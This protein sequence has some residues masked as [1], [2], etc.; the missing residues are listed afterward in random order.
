MNESTGKAVGR[1]LGE[2]VNGFA[3]PV[4]VDIPGELSF[5]PHRDGLNVRKVRNGYVLSA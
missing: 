1:E 2:V 4:R 3:E 5:P